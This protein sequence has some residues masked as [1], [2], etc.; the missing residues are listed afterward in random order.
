MIIDYLLERLLR[1]DAK[2]W[3]VFDKAV[4]R[5]SIVSQQALSSVMIVVDK[6]GNGL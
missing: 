1:T 5:G 2:Y 6:Y 3:C 4:L